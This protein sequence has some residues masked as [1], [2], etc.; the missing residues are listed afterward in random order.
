MA[1]GDN[2]YARLEVD[3]VRSFKFQSLCPGARC[4]YI[5]LW[6]YALEQRRQIIERPP[7]NYLATLAGLKHHSI[8]TYL[9]H[10][11]NLGLTSMNDR[12]IDVIGLEE[13]HKQFTWKHPPF[14][15]NCDQTPP[16]EPNRT[17]RN[18]KD[19]KKRMCVESEKFDI[20][21][22]E[23]PRCINKSAAMKAWSARINAKDSDPD[24]MIAAAQIYAVECNGT[25]DKFIKHPSTFLGPDKPFLDYLEP[26][27]KPNTG[28]NGTAR[29]FD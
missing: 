5:S 28:Q 26:K 25:E 4:L 21:W 20:F 14:D 3:F 29:L 10:M 17:Q 9:E 18:K 22:K 1:K 23:Y 6:C 15:F 8:Q 16:Q 11:H 7:N 13:K 12:Y 2:L 27:K 24:Q 19:A